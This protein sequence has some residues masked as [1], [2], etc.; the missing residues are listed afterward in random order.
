[1]RTKK[2]NN[3]EEHIPTIIVYLNA[4]KTM[5]KVIRPTEHFNMD[6][7]GYV[8]EMFNRRTRLEDGKI[9]NERLFHSYE[10]Q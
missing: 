8:R 1:M 4:E 3:E 5:S 9:I 10:T 7:A 2:F 6:V